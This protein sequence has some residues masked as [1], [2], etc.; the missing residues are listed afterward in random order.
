M[1]PFVLPKATHHPQTREPVF[2]TR[3]TPRDLMLHCVPG[4]LQLQLGS[5]DPT[6]ESKLLGAHLHMC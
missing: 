6:P 5:V 4:A 3:V 1:F 2:D